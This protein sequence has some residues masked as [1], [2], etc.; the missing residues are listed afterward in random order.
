M[1][2]ARGR[3]IS[4]EDKHE[5]IQLISEACSNGARKSKA[6][7]LLG[8]SIRTVERWQNDSEDKRKGADKHV[9][10]RLSAE[11]HELILATM[12]SKE[13]RDLSPCQ[14]VPRLA[15][16]GIYMASE[17]TMYRLL[18]AKSQLAHRSLSSPVKHKKPD[19]HEATGPNEIWSWDITYLPSTVKGIYHFLYMI[20]DVFSR[21]I[22]GWS[23][24]TEQ[25]AEHAANLIQQACLDEQVKRNQLIL[26]SDNGSPMKGATML[27]RL[28]M[29]GVVP[30]FSRPSVSDD[31]PF[32]EALFK[33]LKYHPTFPV[34]DKFSTIFDARGWVV[35][36]VS[37][38]NLEHLHSGLKFITPNQRHTGGDRE[39]MKNRHSVYLKARE[40]HPERWSGKTRDWDLPTLVTLN[41]YR[42]KT[43]SKEVKHPDD[44]C[45][46]ET[47]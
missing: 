4:T 26:H 31:N 25:S 14:I 20:M 16:Q 34:T 39:I 36:F 2:G 23:I 37:W 15:D 27:A 11:E 12:N 38:Y 7:A 33:T 44:G 17:S 41:A 10:N 28:E 47:G 29:L 24:H 30:S 13:Y 1:G 32:S 45:L 9:S 5:A 21:K 18:R 40:K 8:L 35:K 19:M 43:S 42:K 6:C 3:L 22:V 46:K